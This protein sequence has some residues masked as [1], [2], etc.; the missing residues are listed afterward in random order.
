MNL[1][2]Y[3]KPGGKIFFKDYGRYDMTQLRI[4]SE[5]CIEKHRYVRGE[6]TLVYY[7]TQG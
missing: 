6:G 3:L 1:V 7:F 5:R 2:K 4:K